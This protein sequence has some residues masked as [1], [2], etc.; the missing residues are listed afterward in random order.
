[1]IDPS[2]SP[3]AEVNMNDEV[4]SWESFKLTY[5]SNYTK[6]CMLRIWVQNSSG[7]AWF[8]VTKL[9]KMLATK[10]TIVM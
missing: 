9:E 8:D 5:K 7:N 3:L 4:E 6:Y 1:M 10:K 2:K